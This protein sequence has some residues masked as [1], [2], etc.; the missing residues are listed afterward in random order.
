MTRAVLKRDATTLFPSIELFGC[1]RKVLFYLAAEEYASSNTPQN[2]SVH[3]T[4]VK[5]VKENLQSIHHMHIY[6]SI[7]V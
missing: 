5:L 2:T 6:A 1:G 3:Q 7:I 4:A